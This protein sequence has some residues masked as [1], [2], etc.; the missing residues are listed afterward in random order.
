MANVDAPVDV[1]SD[2]RVWKAMD[3]AAKDAQ[4]IHS[5][6]KNE[7]LTIVNLGKDYLNQQPGGTHKDLL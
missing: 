4:N 3:K 7:R 2:I 5:E 1:W 6:A